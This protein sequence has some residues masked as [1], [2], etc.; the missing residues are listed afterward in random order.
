MPDDNGNHKKPH[1][2]SE[3]NM[4]AK[5]FSAALNR[6]KTIRQ[7]QF[8]HTTLERFHGCGLP[9]FHP[10]ATTIDEVAQIVRYQCLTLGGSF[11]ADETQNMQ[12]IARRAFVVAD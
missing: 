4:T 9:D 7:D 8:D 11:D 6:A 3:S 10:I 1:D 5:Q 12:H 2:E